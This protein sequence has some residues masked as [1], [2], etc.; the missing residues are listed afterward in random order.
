MKKS[1]KAAVAAGAAAVL[2]TG[3]AGSLAYWTDSQGV[4][5]GS[6]TSGELKL[7]A[8]SCD[9]SWVYNGTSTAVVK[10]VPGDVVTKKCTFSITATGD[11]LSAKVT[12]PA[13]AALAG[14]SPASSKATVETT[15]A[16]SG[17]GGASGA[18]VNDGVIT[19]ADNAKTLTATFKVSVPFGSDETATPKVNAND[20]Q[21]WTATLNALSVKLTQTQTA[22]NP[23]S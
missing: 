3:G 23:A 11:H 18:V 2:L 9:T 17:T 4:N 10:F 13:T 12:A 21:A 16:L 5:A 14:T 22:A 15:Y 6:I 19:S 20:T 7:G 1:T 8:A